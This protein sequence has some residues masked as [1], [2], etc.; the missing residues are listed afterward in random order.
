MATRRRGLEHKSKRVLELIAEGHSYEQILAIEPSFRYPDIFAAAQEAL[1]ASTA[2][3]SEYG[4]R[5]ADLKRKHTRA[6]DKVDF[7]RGGTGSAA[8]RRRLE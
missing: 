7:R 1:D 5:M 4:D 6:Y 2:H 8:G 3:P